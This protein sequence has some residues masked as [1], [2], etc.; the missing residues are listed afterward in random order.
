MGFNSG[1][2]GLMK[3]PK[4][5]ELRHAQEE[6]QFD[7]KFKS[8]ILNRKYNLKYLNIAEKILFKLILTICY[9]LVQTG[10]SWIWTGPFFVL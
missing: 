10:F 9:L 7:A 4:E 6:K 5:R 3:T 2:K 1:F 8:H